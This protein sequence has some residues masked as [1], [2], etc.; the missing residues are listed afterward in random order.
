MYSDCNNRV[1]CSS[2]ALLNEER[3][4]IYAYKTSLNSRLHPNA[5]CVGN[6]PGVQLTCSGYGALRRKVGGPGGIGDPTL[7]NRSYFSSGCAPTR[8][9]EMVDTLGDPVIWKNTHNK[10]ALN[11]GA[12]MSAMHTRDF[13]TSYASVNEYPVARYNLFPKSWTSGYHGMTAFGGNYNE[14]ALA[15]CRANAKFP[16]TAYSPVSRKSY[17]SFGIAG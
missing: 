13:N 2:K 10:V 4:G 12:G 16:A 6:G 7:V 3:P 11:K 5:V 8:F 17:G 15:T 1:L 14:R 9:N